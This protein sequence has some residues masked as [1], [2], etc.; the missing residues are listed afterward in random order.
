MNDVV[1]LGF[2]DEFR[3]IAMDKEALALFRGAR[4]W[5]KAAKK[6]GETAA[7]AAPVRGWTSAGKMRRALKAERAAPITA[8]PVKAVTKTTSA[9]TTSAAATPAAKTP[10]AGAGKGWLRRNWGKAALIGAPALAVG[11]TGYY[12][13]KILANNPGVSRGRMPVATRRH[14]Y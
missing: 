7:K 5:A 1:M 11:A 14:Y 13:G 10:A 3:K 2:S 8:Q 9:A 6:T 12:G 4:V